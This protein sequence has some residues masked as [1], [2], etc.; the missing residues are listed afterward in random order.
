MARAGH[1]VLVEKYYL[2]HLYGV[3]VGFTK[4]PLAK[5]TYWTN[6]NLIDRAV[7]TA[8]T[9]AVRTGRFV[10]DHIDQ[11]LIDGAIDGSG[12]VSD[13]TG[14]GLRHINSGKVQNYAAILFAGAALLAGAFVIIFA[15]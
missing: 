4:G 9:T 10:Y 5:A 6:Q 7:D 1:K 13:A 15:L 2:D 12:R 3:I 11:T 8:G 14:E